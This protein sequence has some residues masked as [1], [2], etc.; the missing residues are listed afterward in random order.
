MNRSVAIGCIMCWWAVA[1]A[2]NLFKKPEIRDSQSEG[3]IYISVDETFKPIIEEHIRVYRSSYPKANIIARYKSEAECW[4]DMLNDSV[5]LIIVT[6]KLQQEEAAFYNDSLG[7]YPQSGLLAYDAV[8]LLLNRNDP[9][10]VLELSDVQQM[11][12]GKNVLPYRPVFDGVNATSTVRFA[13]DSILR[14]AP[15]NTSVVT[16]AHS[17]WEVVKYIAAN[18]GYIGFV[19][20]SWIANPEDLAQ[21]EMRKLVRIAWLPCRTCEDS[22][23]YTQ[24]WQEEILTGHYPYTRGIYYVIKE[25]YAGLG[26]A[27]VNFMKND[28]GQLIFR[29]G[30]L[31]PAHKPFIERETKIK[32]VKPIK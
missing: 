24:P 9:D 7:L 18:R 6:K 2:C 8:A 5:R 13:L 21:V 4:K 1:S 25:N 17:S 12:Q 10:S 22:L 31:V 32:L 14:G 16:A 30:Y 28:R 27:F 29:R 11:L 15:L 20:V 3:T 26:T 19:G 23:T